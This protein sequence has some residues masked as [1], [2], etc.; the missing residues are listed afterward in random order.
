[1]HLKVAALCELRYR[2]MF[3]RECKIRKD[4]TCFEADGAGT[5]CSKF[6]FLWIYTRHCNLL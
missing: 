2:D 4:L 5:D 1:M 3:H 6:F